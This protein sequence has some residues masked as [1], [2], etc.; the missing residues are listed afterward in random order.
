MTDPDDR[1]QPRTRRAAAA[2]V[3]LD[4]PLIIGVPA[5]GLRRVPASFKWLDRMNRSSTSF[6]RARPAVRVL[7]GGR[8]R[9][10]AGQADLRPMTLIA[11]PIGLASSDA[12][13]RADLLRHVHAGRADLLALLFDPVGTQDR[14]ERREYVDPSTRDPPATSGCTDSTDWRRQP[15]G[16]RQRRP[17][18][19]RADAI[20]DRASAILDLSEDSHPSDTTMTDVQQR[21]SKRPAR[22]KD[23]GGLVSEFVGFMKDNAK[24]WLIPFLIGVRCCSASCSRS[25]DLDR[26]RAVHLHDVL[27]PRGHGQRIPPTPSLAGDRRSARRRRLDRRRPDHCDRAAR[28]RTAPDGTIRPSRAASA[29]VGHWPPTTTLSRLSPAL[30]PPGREKSSTAGVTFSGVPAIPQVPPP[31]G[32][33]RAPSCTRFARRTFAATPAPWPPRG[34]LH[35]R[36]PPPALPRS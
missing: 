18:A 14:Q 22:N 9:R 1:A 17:R 30:A 11:Y 26:R 16:K 5:D 32:A 15:I 35:S 3:R 36:S 7:L 23:Q 29:A 8:H 21:A 4:R 12:A 20:T 13:D 34:W 25:G 2:A 6:V 33:P 24:W 31:C 28:P 19:T 27:S 10:V